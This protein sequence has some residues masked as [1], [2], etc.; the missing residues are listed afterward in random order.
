MARTRPAR[1]W[2]LLLL[3]LAALAVLL[4]LFLP[5]RRRPAATAL[6]A[7]PTGSLN[8]L[9][10]GRDARAVGPVRDEGRR[11]NP[12]EER[13][14]SDVVI[15]ARFNFDLG[16][17]ALYGIPRDLLVHVPGITRD[18]GPT[19]FEN[20]EKLTHVHAIGG[21]ALLRRTLEHLLGITI[22]R[23]IAFDFDSFRMTLNLLR[24]F[25]AGSRVAGVELADHQRALRLARRRA[26]L[27]E[28]DIDR[29]RNN[30]GIVATVLTRTWWLADSRAGR[31]LARRLL[32]IVGEDTDL[33]GPELR[34]VVWGLKHAGWNPRDIR[35]AVLVGEGR[36]IELS[37]Y[38]AVLSCYLPAYGEVR[39]Q[40]ERFLGDDDAVA[41]IDFM[42]R[43]PYAAPGYLFAPRPAPASDTAPADTAALRT[44]QRELERSRP[45]AA[46]PTAGER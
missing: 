30:V 40:V 9:I 35:T 41:A 18:A 24:P 21:P 46:A 10:I 42:T 7:G 45:P 22:D 8:V 32:A 25:L 39:R 4:A 37:R 19:D 28:D 12:R 6:A 31:V 26:G 14:H 23:H 27:A 13:S 11:R 3:P 16:R 44:L 5:D 34:Q 33:T 29:S 17:V 15:I 36:E 38:A 43:Q 2:P 20:M 1:W